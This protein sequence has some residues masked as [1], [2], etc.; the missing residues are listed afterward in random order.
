MI[1]LS[2]KITSSHHIVLTMNNEFQYTFQIIGLS[3]GRAHTV[4]LTDNEGAYTL[5]NNAY[6]Q[7]GRKINPNEEYKGSMVTHNIKRLGK[8]TITDVCCGQD[9][10]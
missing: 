7:C 9:H 4:I 10:T 8:E 3:A 1:P 5:G 2:V 6:G